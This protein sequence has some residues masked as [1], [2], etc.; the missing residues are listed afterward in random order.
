MKK[1]ITI[2]L[3]S[4]LLI[5]TIGIT[6]VKAASATISANK[7][8]VNVGDNVTITVSITGASW[9]VKVNGGGIS[10]T[11]V[12][13][14]EDAENE[15]KT[16]T[17]SL[18]TSNAGSYTVKISGDVTDADD[19]KI[20]PDKSVTITVN[21]PA[22][23][24]VEETPPPS[25]T[26][27]TPTTTTENQ[28]TTTE[29]PPTNTTTGNKKE[30][31]EKPKEISFKEASGTVYTTVNNLNFRS[32]KDGSV[33][34]TISNKGTALERT[35]TASGKVR[36]IYKGK[37]GY[38][39]SNYVSTT[40]PEIKVEE[41]VEEPEEETPPVVEEIKTEEETDVAEFIGKE[42]VLGI[43]AI[44]VI[45]KVEEGK[46][47]EPELMPEFNESEYEYQVA[48]P[49]T[50]TE[51]EV[52][53]ES[54]TEAT[55]EVMGN[56]DLKEGI[57]NV[58]VMVKIGEDT[59]IYQIAVNKVE[60]KPISTLSDEL[61]MQLAVIAAIATVIIVAII[62]LIIAIVRSRKKNKEVESEVKEE[63]QQEPSNE[64]ETENKEE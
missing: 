49:L 21:A 41:K 35:G 39:S 30:E 57:N 7:T 37:E 47:Y 11:I 43:T 58:T 16:K 5:F 42:K 26:A 40:K 64:T 48:V 4:I 6:N 18:D 10:D 13:Y 59:K 45:A 1:S 63:V 9:N 28:N 33:I 50:A 27:E 32:V 36:V 23:K 12:G 20:K 60:M 25:T 31:T 34:E 53:I 24:P 15:T 51:V 2:L 56:K 52:K 62:V 29:V 3:F 17:Y 19:S 61:I 38:V 54:D 22:P 46:D 14:N 8:N 55:I 44:K